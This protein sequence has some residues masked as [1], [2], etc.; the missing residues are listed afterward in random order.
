MP[1]GPPDIRLIAVDLDGTLLDDSGEIPARTWSLL[2]QLRD[3]GILFAPAS[4]RQYA[5][6]VRLFEPHTAGMVF[7]SENGSYAAR[8]GVE[9]TRTSI[10]PDVVA[11]IVRISRDLDERLPGVSAVL[12]GT[13]SGY[14]EP[15]VGPFRDDVEQYYAKLTHV[16]DLLEVTD[17]IL[18]VG[19]HHLGDVEAVLVPHLD[20]LQASARPVVASASWIDIMHPDTSKGAALR[21]VQAKY[22]ISPAQTMAFGDYLNDL[23]LLDAAE[24]SYAMANAHPELQR[25]ARFTAP[26]NSEHGV[27]KVIAEVLG[28][29]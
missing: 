16:D 7:I 26:A 1:P 3:R 6:L 11:E 4:G 12:G 15:S 25:H 29:D 19:V 18:K 9:I 20:H 27:Q 13:R 14:V 24:W 28:L 21:Q 10:D 23:E 22:G 8:D 5:S 17:D 2:E